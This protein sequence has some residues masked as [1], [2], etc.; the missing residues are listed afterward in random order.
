VAVA[1]DDED[2]MSKL[3]VKG[4]PHKAL[5]R[6]DGV[7][8]KNYEVSLPGDLLELLD[9]EGADAPVEP[10]RAAQTQAPISRVSK[11]YV[12]LEKSDPLLVENPQR[13]VMFPIQHADIWEMY[14]K[15]EASFWTAEEVDLSQ[16]NRDWDNLSDQERHFVTPVIKRMITPAARTPANM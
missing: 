7:V 6:R 14:K 5:I 8:A 15:H 3:G 10:E 9:A 1:D 11:Q 4:L 13:W 2:L 12:E 16:D